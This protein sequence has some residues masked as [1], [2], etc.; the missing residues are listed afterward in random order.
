[1]KFDELREIRD[2][3]GLS[4][5]VAHAERYIFKQ[6]D[7]C[8]EALFASG[9]LIQTNAEAFVRFGVGRK[10]M[11]LL[12]CGRVNFL[13]SDCHGATFRAPN[14]KDALIKIE[15][16]LGRAALEELLREAYDVFEEHKI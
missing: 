8:R 16:R 2:L 6:S 9:A 1:M 11:K 13:G 4:P 7:S 10:M 5:I 15:K 12:S 14:V 3:R